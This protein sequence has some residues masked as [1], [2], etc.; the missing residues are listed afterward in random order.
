M[1]RS[2]L[3][4]LAKLRI[5]EVKILLDHGCFEGAYY[6]AGYAIECGL[7]ACIARQTK[8]FD[9][10]DLELVRASYTHKL[11]D[12]IKVAGLQTD[13]QKEIKSNK[14]FETNWAVVKDWSEKGR[15]RTRISEAEAGDLYSAIMNRK[16][17]VFLWL[18][19]RW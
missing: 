11:R 17:G 6:L 19:K 3:R 8:R 12:L 13:F 7:K 15:Y 9:F 2:D 16:N 10:P 4:R 1:N 18:K 14:S 5:Q